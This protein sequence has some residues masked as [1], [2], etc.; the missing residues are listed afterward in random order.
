MRA[1]GHIQ[2]ARLTG[3]RISTLLRELEQTGRQDHESGTGLSPRT[4]RYC[5]TLLK[6]ALREAVGHGLIATNPAD[7]AKPPAARE[8]KA[9]EIRPWTAGQ[10]ST[11]MDWATEHGCPDAVAWRV[12]AYTGMRRGELLALRWRD[13]DLDAAAECPPVGGDCE[14]QRRG[15]AAG[16]GTDKDGPA[17]AC[18]S[19]FTDCGVSFGGIGLPVQVSTCGWPATTR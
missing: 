5:F 8:A 13:L 10:R 9:P 14:D 18:G 11:F 12:L 17:A 1:L 4:V 3:T 16:R 6:V 15:R 2:L 19:G 7:K